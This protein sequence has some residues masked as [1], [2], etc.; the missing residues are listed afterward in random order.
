R[1]F[2]F[3]FRAFFGRF[4]EP[5]RAVLAA[6]RHRGKPGKSGLIRRFSVVPVGTPF[7]ISVILLSTVTVHNRQHPRVAG[8]V[9]A[10]P[11]EFRKICSERS[12]QSD[13]GFVVVRLVTAIVILIGSLLCAALPACAQSDQGAPPDR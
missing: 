5:L 4:Q 13:M 9:A 7:V 6:Y 2:A 8:Q 11:G 12:V 1:E 3:F 10:L